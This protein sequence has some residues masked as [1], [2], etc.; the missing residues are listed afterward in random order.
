MPIRG[1][2]TVA[3]VEWNGR[4][5]YHSVSSPLKPHPS[6]SAPSSRKTEANVEPGAGSVDRSPDS[7]ATDLGEP[8]SN[9]VA[10]TAQALQ[11]PLC[12]D[13]DGTLTKVDTLYDTFMLL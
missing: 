10:D 11:R 6:A 13:L 8:M 4:S 1:R 5:L 2:G 7:T 12:V 9:A 3:I